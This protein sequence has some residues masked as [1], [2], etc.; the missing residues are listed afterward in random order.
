MT[1]LVLEVENARLEMYADD[2]TLYTAAKSVDTINSTLTAQAKPV[3]CWI[4][5]NLMVL[6]GDKTECCYMVQ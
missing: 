1:D 3:Y 2:S 5:I 4:S 6:N